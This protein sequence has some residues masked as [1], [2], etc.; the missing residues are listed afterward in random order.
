[1]VAARFGRRGR[2]DT[3]DATA[4]LSCAHG[5]GSSSKIFWTMCLAG[6][7]LGLGFVGDGDPVA[8][9]IH[10]DALHVLGRDIAAAAEEGVGLGGEGQGDGGARAR[11]P[12]G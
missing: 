5:T 6:L 2:F 7:L 9:D 3:D 11:R 1:M 8:Q 12:A 4:W 10:A